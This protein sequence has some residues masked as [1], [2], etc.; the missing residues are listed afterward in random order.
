M[1]LYCIFLLYYICSFFVEG[2][3]VHPCKG[4]IL[5]NEMFLAQFPI[6]FPC[7]LECPNNFYQ[8]F[9]FLDFFLLALFFHRFLIFFSWFFSVGALNFSHY[10]QIKIW[11][12]LFIIILCR[13]YTYILRLSLFHMKKKNVE[14]IFEIFYDYCKILILS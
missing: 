14:K 10:R 12:I 1:T 11:L 2:K 9:F 13:F 6:I 3:I 4:S 8:R 5:N 7:L